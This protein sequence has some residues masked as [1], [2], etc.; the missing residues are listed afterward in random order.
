M[1]RP[2]HEGYDRRVVVEAARWSTD[3]HHVYGCAFLLAAD[4]C[5]FDL[6][7]CLDGGTWIEGP[8]PLRSGNKTRTKN[9]RSVRPDE[10]RQR[11][12]G[13]DI[14]RLTHNVNGS[15][16]RFHLPIE[17]D[18]AGDKGDPVHAI[19]IDLICTDDNTI[20]RRPRNASDTD[21]DHV[22]PAV[23]IVHFIP[24]HCGDDDAQTMDFPL[25]DDNR[26]W[27]I[28]HL[29]MGEKRFDFVE[30][31][32]SVI[33][34]ASASPIGRPVRIVGTS[35]T[36]RTSQ[37]PL[38]YVLTD[39]E[40]THA[41]THGREASESARRLCVLETSAQSV[42][43]CDADY[44]TRSVC[45]QSWNI[46]FSDFGVGFFCSDPDHD[47]KARN[48][49]KVISDAW[50]DLVALELLQFSIIEWF[51]D[52]AALLAEE[53]GR[54][55]S[56]RGAQQLGVA[57]SEQIGPTTRALWTQFI[58]FQ[59]RYNIAEASSKYAHSR[60]LVGFESQF[61][62][63]INRLH[64]RTR[65]NLDHLGQLAKMESEEVEAENQRR[66]SALDRREARAE[67]EFNEV[68]GLIA[69][70]LLPAT[71]TLDVLSWF[72]WPWWVNAAVFAAVV[73]LGLLVGPR[74]LRWFIARRIDRRGLDR[75]SEDY[76]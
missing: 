64:Q 72:T 3:A 58:A 66:L 15:V 11:I 24:A 63:R 18:L 37:I 40:G 69:T 6:E 75:S 46:T 22:V 50:V 55:V 4:V 38:Y 20:V 23:L 44:A 48:H 7:R 1:T 5:F 73:V 16:N 29:A 9:T 49:R 36:P 76:R 47:D 60:V 42:D 26:L 35:A 68:V 12:L 70:V 17:F 14:S 13:P 51:A 53:Y 2:F 25:F 34:G 21:G 30:C 67:R 43:T 31:L 10:Q 59:A 8:L 39:A 52:R 61:T 27:S 54:R 56:A 71:I 57:S 33:D 41:V 28:K 65:D 19:G 45:V 32:Q 74:S 62:N